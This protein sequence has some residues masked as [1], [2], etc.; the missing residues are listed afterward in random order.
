MLEFSNIRL[1]AGRSAGLMLTGTFYWKILWRTELSLSF[2]HT[3][4]LRISVSPH[5]SMLRIPHFFDQGALEGIHRV[6]LIRS[7]LV[8]LCFASFF[9]PCWATVPKDT[10]YLQ[11]IRICLFLPPVRS[12]IWLKGCWVVRHVTFLVRKENYDRP[13]Y[14]FVENDLLNVIV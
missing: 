8:L 6:L 11:L 13:K 12:W 14:L 2:F 5:K 10:H 1:D 4:I 7:N 3:F 9:I